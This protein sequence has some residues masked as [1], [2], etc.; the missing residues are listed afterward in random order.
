M[1]VSKAYSHGIPDDESFRAERENWRL[2]MSESEELRS[3]AISLTIKSDHFKYGYQWDWCGIPII[4]HPDDVMLLQELIW[5]L[6]P[7]FVVETGIARGGSLALSAD[8]M[9]LT[10]L[11][12]R[13]LGLDLQILPHAYIAL[14]RYLSD[15][16]VQMYECDSTS[17]SAKECVRKFIGE[18]DEPG[19]LILDSNHSQSHVYAELE[20][21]APLLP[22]GSYIVIC[23]TI[24]EEMPVD[25]YVNR[26]WSRGNNPLTA[27]QAFL[28]DNQDFIL[29]KEWSR[30]SL[31]GE[32]R[33]GILFRSS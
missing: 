20:I 24:V 10:D 15:S 32:C 25:Y 17:N 6:R 13:V 3:L 16:R 21:L 11:P 19:L 27:A 2:G 31:M 7:S 8:L 29:A 26:P 33:D 12:P 30:R 4:K 23:D 9:K 18:V 14:E 28:K 5:N 1:T 22:K